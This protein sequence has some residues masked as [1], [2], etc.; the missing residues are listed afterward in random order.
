MDPWIKFFLELIGGGVAWGLTLYFGKGWFEEKV[1]KRLD[2]FETGLRSVENK[3]QEAVSEAKGSAFKIL[4]ANAELRNDWSKE[5]VKLS[6]LFMEATKYSTAAEHQARLAH[7]KT[8]ALEKIAD[9]KI[10]QAK[11]IGRAL[12]GKVKLVEEASAKTSSE[13]QEIR[14]DVLLIKGKK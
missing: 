5:Q 4:T 3:A 11:A 2:K 14:K 8:Q 6:Q 10:E 12:N 13:V 9:E 7:D 1:L